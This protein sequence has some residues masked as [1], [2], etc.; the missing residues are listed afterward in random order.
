MTKWVFWRIK[1]FKWY[2]KKSVFVGIPRDS[3]NNIIVNIMHFISHLEDILPRFLYLPSI[4]LQWLIS[5]FDHSLEFGQII[6]LISFNHFFNH[7]IR[8]LLLKGWWITVIMTMELKGLWLLGGY[9][10]L[11]RLGRKANTG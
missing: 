11:W 10:R 2:I 6:A 7:L 9:Y 3:V 5:L 4:I 8:I 1:W